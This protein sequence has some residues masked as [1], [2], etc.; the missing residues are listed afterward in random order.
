MACHIMSRVPEVENYRSTF[1][2]RERAWRDLTC[3]HPQTAKGIGEDD[4][5]ADNVEAELR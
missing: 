1:G 5:I 3:R 4:G 2:G